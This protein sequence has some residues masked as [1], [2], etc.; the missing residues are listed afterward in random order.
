MKDYTLIALA[1]DNEARIYVSRS[2]NLVEKARKIHQTKPT[3]SAALGRFL[4]VSAMMSLMYKD[5]ERLQLKITGSGPIEKMTVDAKFGV[6]KATIT[7]PDV[8]LVYQEGPKKGKLDVGAAVGS[9][10]LHITKDYK[11]HYFTSSSP[12]QTGEI[13]DDFT[14]FYATSEQTPSAVGLGVLVARGVS[15]V[16]AGGFI[17][18][19]LPHASDKTI[20]LIEN[21][22]KTVTSI[23]DLLKAEETPESILAKL[24]NETHQI[25]EKHEIK[26]HCGCSKKQYERVLKTLDKAS[27][28]TMLRED[29]GAEIV[30][31][32]C[33]KKY[34]FDESDLQKI[35]NG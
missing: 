23:T 8:Y 6:V 22:L 35:I 9:G 28:N 3:A 7:N 24:S 2:T 13:G 21:V 34:L 27:L 25:L 32:Y 17:I 19:V 15:V 16:A 20:T 5:D 26:Y 11:G 1:Y 33:N 4:T 14:Y 12:L 10:F 29:K 18:Q 31:H 30:C